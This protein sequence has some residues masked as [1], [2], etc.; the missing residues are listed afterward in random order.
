[1]NKKRTGRLQDT[2]T[3]GNFFVR[4][5]TTEILLRAVSTLRT[6]FDIVEEIHGSGDVNDDAHEG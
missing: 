1:M 6:K 2:N 5:V 4:E 3:L